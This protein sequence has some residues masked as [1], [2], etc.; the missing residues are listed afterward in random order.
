VLEAKQGSDKPEPPADGADGG[1][2][3]ARKLK[4]GTATRGTQVWDDAMLAARGQAEMYAKALPLS[5]GWPPFLIVVDVGHSVELYSDFSRSGKTYVPFPDPRSH[6]FPLRDLAKEEI[7]ERLRLIWTD[8]LALDPTR[9]SARITREVAVRLGRLARSLEESGH[10]PERV[11]A[12]LMRC[13]FT[14]FAEDVR[15]LR[16]GGFTALLESLRGTPELFPEMVH[17][18]WETMNTGGF[19]PILRQKLLRF[20]GGLF[21]SCE[22]LPLTEAQLALLIEASKS[23]WRDVEPA[24]F[25]TLLERALDPVER[26][27]LG[28]HYTPR[29]YVER[30]VLPTLVEPVREEWEAVRVAAVTLAKEGK[31]DEAAAQVR[32]FHR[33]LCGI[34]VLDPACGSGNFLYVALEHLKRLEGEV[35][36]TLDSF[37]QTHLDLEAETLTVDPHQLLG[38]EINP[39]AAAI[40]D[41]VLWIGYLQWHFRTRGEAMPEEP[42]I[43]KFHNIECRDAVL[44]YDARE[45]LLDEAGQ[46]VTRWDGRTFKKHPVTGQDVR[47]VSACVPCYRYL[48]PRKAEWPAAD[49]VVGNPP[50]IGA[51][52]IRETLSDEYLRSLRTAYPEV[53]EHSDY[54]MYWWSRAAEYVKQ[55]RLNRFGFITTN[56]ISQ[57]FSRKLITSFLDAGDQFVIR[58]AI[59]DHPW[60]EASHGANVRVAMTVCDNTGKSGILR[61][62]VHEEFAGEE[63]AVGFVD[64]VGSIHAD[65]SVGVKLVEARALHSNAALCSVGYQLSGKGFILTAEST[66]EHRAADGSLVAGIIKPL[67]TG[68]DITQRLRQLRVIDLYSRGIDEVRSQYPSIYQRVYNYVKPERDHNNEPRF[69]QMWWIFSRPRPEFRVASAN[70]SRILATSLTAKH[71]IFVFLSAD[72]IGDSTTVLFALDDPHYLGVLSSRIHVIWAV[73]TGGRMGV[74]NDSR[75]LKAATFDP[76]PFPDPTDEQRARIRELGEALDAH[77][78]RQQAQHPKLTLTDMYNVLEKLRAETPLTEKEKAIHEQGLVSVL[79]QFHDELDAAVFAAYGW[80]ATLT[81]EEILERLVLLNAERAAEE[82][83]GLVRWLRPEFQNPQGAGQAA[84]DTGVGEA[85]AVAAVAQEKTPWPKALPDQAKAVRAALAQQPG[86][87][88]PEELARSFK[89][90]R[91]DR[92]EALL[93]TLASLGQAREVEAGRFAA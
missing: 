43:R 75:Y 34:R 16:E 57:P 8:P 93:A 11:A 90:A 62:V 50:F 30:L 72:T 65:L 70:I 40:T 81:D 28:A 44:E 6:R 4:R 83:R 35:L 12:F 9:R 69:R 20:N 87:V 60:I 67:V 59:P 54:V 37:G 19:S 61:E 68:R 79:K 14:M 56:S 46:P 3:K 66:L 22:A 33:R 7:R 36:N 45:P 41:L 52:H 15:L 92:V 71:R 64:R 51:R 38:I 73:A 5:E 17:S 49:Y 21:E 55:S 76:F 27:R 29:A 63:A 47:D 82:R 77:R 18:L 74:G 78:K 42:V 26:H 89:G 48:N 53:P 86:V 2:G 23:D 10:A 85:A 58:F 88:T 91:V 84:L 39:R 1:T 13:I 25:G 24:I 80:P 32:D 31:L